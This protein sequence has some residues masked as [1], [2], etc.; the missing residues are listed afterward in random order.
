MMPGWCRVQEGR[1]VGHQDESRMMEH[2]IQLTV[3]E[4]SFLLPESFTCFFTYLS[5][6]LVLGK[7]L[8]G[9]RNPPRRRRHQGGRR[10]ARSPSVSKRHQAR[11]PRPAAIPGYGLQFVAICVTCDVP[12]GTYV[13]CRRG[14]V[15]EQMVK[16]VSSLIS[17]RSLSSLLQAP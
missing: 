5:I 15:L 14:C 4:T 11:I 12:A 2:V 3:K 16:V 8:V 7:M 6:V 9:V 1:P 17:Q 10:N 13:C